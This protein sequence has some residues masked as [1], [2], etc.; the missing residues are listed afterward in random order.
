MENYPD[1]EAASP[2]VNDVDA[3]ALFLKA[4]SAVIGPDDGRLGVNLCERLTSFQVL[5]TLSALRRKKFSGRPKTRAWTATT[6]RVESDVEFALET[7]G[8]VARALVAEFEVVP[9]ALRCCA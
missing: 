7:D 9:R 2:P 6:V 4:P 8:E 1:P 5:A 3:P